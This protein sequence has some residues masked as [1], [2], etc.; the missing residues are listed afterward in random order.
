MPHGD[1]PRPAATEMR[2]NRAADDDR[3]AVA[4][5]LEERKAEARLEDAKMAG[6]EAV[7]AEA[8]LRLHTEYR[9]RLFRAL[10]G[11]VRR[12]GD[13]ARRVSELER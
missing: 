1:T 10:C 9:R 5:L 11:P 3:D 2:G 8:R 7:I 4:E 12:P 13:R 6:D